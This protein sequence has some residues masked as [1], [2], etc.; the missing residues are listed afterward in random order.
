VPAISAGTWASTATADEHVATNV[1]A[2]NAAA[3][4]SFSSYKW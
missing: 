3:A 4:F 1:Y 2:T